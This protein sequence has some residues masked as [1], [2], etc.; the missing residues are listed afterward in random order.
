MAEWYSHFAKEGSGLAPRN[1]ALIA[2]LRESNAAKLVELEATIKDAEENL[3]DTEVKDAEIAKAQHFDKT[4][5]MVRRR[6]RLPPRHAFRVVQLFFSLSVCTCACGVCGRVAP[7][8][9]KVAHDPASRAGQGAGVIRRGG[10][11]GEGRDG[12]AAH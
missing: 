1:E 4:G 3:G 8:R 9:F 11:R 10:R 2:K 6:N 7:S 5:D 12:G